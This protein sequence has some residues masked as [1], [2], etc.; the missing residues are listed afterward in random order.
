VLGVRD[1]ESWRQI[2]K[3][4]RIFFDRP[5]PTGGC[6]TNGR[7]RISTETTKSTHRLK[8]KSHRTITYIYHNVSLL[9]TG[10]KK[11]THTKCIQNI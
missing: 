1:A 8:P 2:G 3:N 5:K 10:L 4:D 6:S 9:L 7:R 11:N